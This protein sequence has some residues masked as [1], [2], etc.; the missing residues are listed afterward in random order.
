MVALPAQR[1]T[2]L[3]LTGLATFGFVLESLVREEKLLPRRENELRSAVHALQDPIL[4]LHR[5][6]LLPEQSP[7]RYGCELAEHREA[8][9]VPTLPPLLDL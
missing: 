7:T 1:L 5:S 9:L 8:C 6:T 2:A 4:V 3:H